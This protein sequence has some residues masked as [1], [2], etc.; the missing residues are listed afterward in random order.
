[1]P[2]VIYVHSSPSPT[3][4]YDCTQGKSAD[5]VTAVLHERMASLLEARD[6]AYGGT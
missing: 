3:V 4:T 5:T 6:C 2:L 1:M